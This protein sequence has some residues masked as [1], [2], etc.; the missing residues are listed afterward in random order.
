MFQSKQLCGQ[1][2]AKRYGNE[3]ISYLLNIVFFYFFIS[4]IRLSGS[5]DVDSAG[6]S[7]RNFFCESWRNFSEQI[8]VQTRESGVAFS[9]PTDSSALFVFYFVI[10]IARFFH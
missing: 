7:N 2:K 5:T 8:F 1:S 10:R 9:S 6:S 4:N 3:S